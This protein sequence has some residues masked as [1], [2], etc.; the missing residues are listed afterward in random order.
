MDPKR[1]VPVVMRLSCTR[2]DR[3]CAWRPM[4]STGMPSPLSDE[5]RSWLCCTLVDG[6]TQT[7]AAAAVMFTAT[8]VDD[9]VVLAVLNIASRGLAPRGGGKS[10][11]PNTSG[12]R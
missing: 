12:S 7:I 4:P 1:L 11:S 10:G 8:N 2:P 3:R 9:A 5:H 6:I